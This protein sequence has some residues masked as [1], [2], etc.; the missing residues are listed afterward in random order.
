MRFLNWGAL[1]N[2]AFQRAAKRA[3]AEDS[4][5]GRKYEYTPFAADG[6]L[7]DNDWKQHPRG[8]GYDS[9]IAGNGHTAR[10]RDALADI[11]KRVEEVYRDYAKRFRLNDSAAESS[12]RADQPTKATDPISLDQL[13][14]GAGLHEDVLRR[15]GTLRAGDTIEQLKL[16]DLKRLTDNPQDAAEFAKKLGFDVEYF[17]FES[18]PSK[19]VEFRL[20]RLGKNGYENGKL[21]LYDPRI[22]AGSF[23]DTEYT[24]AW[25]ITHEL[26]HALTEPLLQSRYGD[27]R[28]YGRLGQTLDV[29]RGVL[30]KQRQ[31]TERP[32]TLMEA[33]RAVEWEDAAFRAQREVLKQLGVAISDE[34]FAREYNV[35]LSDAVY[36]VLSGNFG[37]PALSGFVPKDS[38]QPMKDVL[39]LLAR[40]E[41]V[42]AKSQGREPTPGIDG[43]SYR[44]ISDAEIRQALE[45]RASGVKD[46]KFAARADEAVDYRVVVKDG[47]GNELDGPHQD[48]LF[49]NEQ[50]ASDHITTMADMH[51]GPAGAE[52][53]H[54]H[55]WS[56]VTKGGKIDRVFAIEPVSRNP[57][58]GQNPRGGEGTP[59]QRFIGEFEKQYP[60]SGEIGERL[61]NGNTVVSMVHDPFKANTA[62]V[63][64]VRALTPGQGD[65][66]KALHDVVGL[67]DKHGVALELNAVPIGTSMQ[68]RQLID[69]YKKLGFREVGEPESNAWGATSQLMRREPAEKPEQIPPFATNAGKGISAQDAAE[70]I[71]RAKEMFPQAVHHLATSIEDTPHEVQAVAAMRGLTD[72]VQAAYVREYDGTHVYLVQNNMRSVDEAL[73]TMVEEN[74][75]H[76]GIAK[77]FGPAV[78]NLMDGFLRNEAL[79]PAII[80]MAAREGINLRAAT[81]PV[82]RKEA[83]RAAAE[84]WLAHGAAR[85][86]TGQKSP[87]GLQKAVRDV[88]AAVKVWA[89]SKGLGV[90]LGH[91]EALHALAKAHRY[92]TSGDWMTRISE[93]REEAEAARVKFAA[94][95]PSGNADLDELLNDKIGAPKVGWRTRLSGSMRDFRSERVIEALDRMY[96]VKQYEDDLKVPP[97]ESGYIS[98]RL[99]TNVAPLLRNLIEFGHLKWT[100][101]AGADFDK[102]MT[103]D[104]KE[105]KPL[106]QI[107]APLGNDPQMLRRFEGYLVAL[108]SRELMAQGRENLLEQ[109]HIQAG[110]DLAT[111]YPHFATMQKELMAIHK[112]MLD[113]GE[114]GGVIDPESRKL[115]ESEYYTPLYRVVDEAGAGPWSA[116][117]LAKVRNPIMRLMG[118]KENVND[119]LGNIV[120]N[121]STIINASIKA[122]AVRVAVDNLSQAG[123]AVR[124][125]A[126]ER[127]GDALVSTSEINKLLQKHGITQALSPSAIGGIQKL[128]SLSTPQGDDVVQVWRGGKREYYRL[129][130]QSLAVAFAAMKGSALKNLEDDRIGRAIIGA[131]RLPKQAFTYLTTHLPLFG[132]RTLYKDN[133]NAWTVGRGYMPV[134]PVVSA[135]TGLVKTMRGSEGFKRM[136]AAGA[137]FNAGRADPY[138]ANLTAK[139]Y[140]SSPSLVGR[141][142]GPY[143]DFVTA[144]ENAS[145]VTIYERTLKETGSHKIAAYEARDLMDYAMRG[146]SPIIQLLVETVPFWGAHVQGIY[147]TA[148]SFVPENS[149]SWSQIAAGAGKRMAPILLKGMLLSTLSMGLYMHNRDNPAYQE[150]TDLDKELYYHIFVGS[151]HIKIPKAF[152]SGTVFGTVPELIADAA[153]SKDPQVAKEDA[154]SLAHAFGAGLNLYPRV[155]ALT[156]L[157]ELYTNHNTST[158]APILS[159]FDQKLMP[160]EQVGPSTSAAVT[161]IARNMP[162]MAPDALQ[163][164][165]RLQHLIQ[166]YLGLAGSYGMAAA[167]YLYRKAVD[168]PAPADRNLGQIP[169][170]GQVVTRTDQPPTQ[171]RS[172]TELSNIMIE[173]NKV[174]DTIKELQK[175][176]DQESLDRADALQQQNE[177]LLNAGDQ[178][179]PLY[180]DIRKLNAAKR[181]IQQDPDM[182][183]KEKQEQLNEIQKD[184]NE[185][186]RDAYQYRPGSK[187]SKELLDSTT[188]AVTPAE[189]ARI[190]RKADQ[191]ALASIV[192][193]YAKGMPA[194][195]QSAIE[196]LS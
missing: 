112:N 127:G 152:E 189:K 34:D 177:E 11:G 4:L 167:D 103:P 31:V 68:S 104:F 190:L 156:P 170:V 120:R 37:D 113:F 128:M 77:T 25:R 81:T 58:K 100:G 95:P 145:R 196:E 130:D 24:R 135:I 141:L 154:Q 143:R 139:R 149:R 32:L 40:A 43:P 171:T 65:G 15:F 142:W 123:V 26:G 133:I 98:M 193:Q 99:S 192:A 28:R 9:V 91:A 66:T 87:Q 169:L 117:S 49:N 180:D 75:G 182:S 41:D 184:I 35:N 163:S 54:N 107:L 90:T 183:G 165:K 126:L 102:S 186:A 8:E 14:T 181:Q 89:A 73:R 30:G 51:A 116:G 137:T 175:K 45:N 97:A 118:S 158:G 52:V 50:D 86:I 185:E 125:P 134:T 109:R 94:V 110:L 60:E 84:E 62:Y 82:A 119:V 16:Y 159:D 39:G 164:P 138:D 88:V 38:A 124:V 191:P 129:A 92:V 108:R 162:G 179:R 71:R 70:V 61:V 172:L 64:Y 56:Q 76:D 79:R 74:V 7:I 67:A 23:Y 10:I 27:S 187:L 111:T 12:A 21:W 53:D 5:F 136:A 42:L 150:L 72:R 17:S 157:W 3:F 115:W 160:S 6:G 29:A 69:W 176:E 44:P 18:D 101:T 63:P 161:A 194:S 105:G 178:I 131:A 121:W 85:E 48:L 1:D 83:L 2:K 151:Y 93:Q 55:F 13:K 36:R 195:V 46:V 146:S 19:G 57:F 59:A 47:K 96:R 144:G 80:E 147:K 174:Q 106:N 140:L 153:M 132:I 114:G 173:A 33:Q 122:H 166:G 188:S 20:P 148:R 168:L 155:T 22:G 78:G